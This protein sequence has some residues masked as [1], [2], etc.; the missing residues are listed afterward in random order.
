MQAQT[1]QINQERLAAYR[2]TLLPAIKD[3]QQRMLAELGR[4]SSEHLDYDA[5]QTPLQMINVCNDLSMLSSE[6]QMSKYQQLRQRPGSPGG[7]RGQ[8]S[9]IAQVIP[10]GGPTTQQPGGEMQRVALTPTQPAEPQA[11]PAAPDSGNLRPGQQTGSIGDL[12][13]ATGALDTLPQ[14]WRNVATNDLYRI[15]FD[16]DHII[17]FQQGSN[18]VV[19][20]LTLKKGK[21]SG[22]TSLSPCQGGGHMEVSSWSTTRIEAKIEVPDANKMCGGIGGFG[23]AIGR[24]MVQASFIPEAAPVR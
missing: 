21:Y 14:L 11:T 22:T 13:S 20:D 2:E 16:S 19:A 1:N 17:I 15:R 12:K 23:H 6:Y 18:Q 7:Y 3:L 5:V 9:T 10:A 24:T 4:S 8:P